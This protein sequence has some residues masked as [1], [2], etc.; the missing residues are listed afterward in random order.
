M[1]KYEIVRCVWGNSYTENKTGQV[2]DTR[3]EAEKNA[4]ETM[5]S[6]EYQGSLVTFRVARQDDVPFEVYNEFI[7]ACLA[8][9]L[10]FPCTA[11]RFRARAV[12]FARGNDEGLIDALYRKG[13]EMSFIIH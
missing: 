13:M 10:E 5:A 11:K 2:Y 4:A 3:A 12:W 7:E 6:P 9:G 8:E 1:K